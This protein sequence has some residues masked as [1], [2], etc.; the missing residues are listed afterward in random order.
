MK[1]EQALALL[2]DFP[3][4]PPEIVKQM[5]NRLKQYLIV[6]HKKNTC[7]C[8]Y[9]EKSGKIPKYYYVA[10]REKKSCPKCGAEVTVIEN[11]HNFC[12][13]VIESEA[14]C[15]VCLNNP[16][17][18][19]LYIS[20]YNLTLYFAR[21]EPRPRIKIEETQRYIFTEKSA[22][23]Y[24]RDKVWEQE[25]VLPGCY[26][27]VYT[28]SDWQVRTKLTEPVFR[29]QSFGRMYEP[30]Y[31]VINTAAI[32]NTCMRY[33]ALDM[34]SDRISPIKYLIYYRKHP[35]I[36]R[37][38]KLGMHD[39]VKKALSP[40][41][42]IE[43]NYKETEPHKMLGISRE[44]FGLVRGGI[45]LQ[46]VKSLSEHFHDL[47]A[48]K[49]PIYHAIIRNQYGTLDS[50]CNLTHTVPEQPLKYLI[51][52]R[53]KCGEHIDIGYYSDYINI[54]RGIGYN[55]TDSVVLYPKDL[56]AA[57]D[58]VVSARAAIRAEKERQ[59]NIERDKQLQA[60][61]KQRKALEYCFGGYVAILPKSCEEIVQEGAALRHC[62]AGYAE[63]HAA[64][65][66]TIMFLRRANELD[67][68]YYTMEI[69]LKYQII[70]CRGYRNN[71]ELSGGSPKPQAIKDFEEAYQ[72]Y[73]DKLRVKAQ[74]QKRRVQNTQEIILQTGA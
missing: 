45:D 16:D 26:R 25:M 42:N 61:Q 32:S 60:L 67:K 52:Q 22:V 5:K 31:C 18:D 68:P 38:V 40:Y 63:R 50:V 33:C 59:K 30:D 20:C 39:I 73:L 62:V 28:W 58:R 3:R 12:G 8:T 10:H 19:N 2:D 21:A 44:M 14:N 34:I 72:A 54:C 47:S 70:Q 7:Y 71:V 65:A 24:G 51:R 56:T 11:C 35:G 49:Y 53:A 23:R 29:H 15:V 69:S 41:N 74:K 13:S 55:L 6:D 66:L 1:K 27:Y 64:G 48:D 46:S 17:N 57:H 36:E 43:I 4:T 37:F 9:C